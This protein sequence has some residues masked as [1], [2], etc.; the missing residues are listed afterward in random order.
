MTAAPGGHEAPT[1]IP[2]PS[3]FPVTWKNPEDEGLF[4]QTDPMH[5]PEPTTP[6]MVR[7]GEAINEG[8]RLAG[9]A[10]EMPVTLRYHRINTYHYKTILPAVPPGEM[11]AQGKR[12]D[13]NLQPAIGRLWALWDSELLPEFKGILDGDSAAK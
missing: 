6:I 2:P 8:F 7:V 13:A 5:F 10:Y 4:W 9:L 1:P 11:E 3:N 12:A